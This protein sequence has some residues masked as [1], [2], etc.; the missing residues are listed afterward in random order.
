MQPHVLYRRFSS[1]VLRVHKAENL[2]PKRWS[3]LHL[4]Q[5]GAH[6]RT[7]GRRSRRFP[8]GRGCGRRCCRGDG[9]ARHGGGRAARRWVGTGRGAAQRGAAAAAEAEAAGGGDGCRGPRL[10]AGGQLRP[11]SRSGGGSPVP[12]RGSV[13]SARGPLAPDV[14]GVPAGPSG[15]SPSR[16]RCRSWG[17]AA[18]RNGARRSAAAAGARPGRRRLLLVRGGGAGGA[19]SRGLRGCQRPAVDAEPLTACR[20]IAVP[21][22]RENRCGELPGSRIPRRSQASRAL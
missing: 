6:R 9:S 12:R 20:C 16:G 21:R 10:L 3:G 18:P 2:Y 11:P 5:R 13:A 8:A 4:P 19:P 1:F 17:H 22:H 7:R 15:P 14:G